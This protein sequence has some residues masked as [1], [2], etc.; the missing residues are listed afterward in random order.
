MKK[1]TTKK[2]KAIKKKVVKI[3]QDVKKIPNFILTLNFNDKQMITE[4]ATIEECLDQI[5][6]SERIKTK[7]MLSISHDG[8]TVI[9]LMH[10][11]E[12]KRLLIKKVN[13]EFF[14]KKI[15]SLMQ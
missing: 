14:E 13:K 9:K 8:N 1:K 6:L 11:F 12:F 5:D 2:E 3:V 4:G 7:T 15:L 10:P